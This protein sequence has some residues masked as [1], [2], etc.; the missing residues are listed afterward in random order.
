MFLDRVSTMLDAQNDRSFSSSPDNSH[1][2]VEDGTFVNLPNQQLLQQTDIETP[3]SPNTEHTG[4]PTA[5]SLEDEAE[6]SSAS[7]DS[8][9]A[10]EISR[11]RHAAVTVIG[12]LTQI[13]GF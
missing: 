9:T 1:Y 4:M 8:N 3:T 6:V 2:N 12:E 5:A 10:S 11:K 7:T 13:F